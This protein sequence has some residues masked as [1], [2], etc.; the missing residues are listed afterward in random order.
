VSDEGRQGREKQILRYA[1]FGYAPFGYAQ[2]KQ[3]K[4]GKQDDSG[5]DGEGGGDEGDS[6]ERSG[7]PFAKK[8][9]AKGRP[10]RS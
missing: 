8:Q 2:G 1:P 4:Q 10:P 6:M 3:G 7:R 9:N 5:G